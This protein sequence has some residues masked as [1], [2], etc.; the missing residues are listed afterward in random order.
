M[1]FIKIFFSDCFNN[2]KQSIKECSEMN[3][4]LKSLRRDWNLIFYYKEKTLEMYSAALSSRPSII[5]NLWENLDFIKIFSRNSNTWM[6][7]TLDQINYLM[8]MSDEWYIHIPDSLL[9]ALICERQK[10]KRS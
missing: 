7:L 8:K 2:I 5:W 10:L 4:I 1:E 3:S 6:F 9:M